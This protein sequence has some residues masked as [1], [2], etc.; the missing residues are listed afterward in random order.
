MS[1]NNTMSLALFILN[2]N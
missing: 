2:T 1:M